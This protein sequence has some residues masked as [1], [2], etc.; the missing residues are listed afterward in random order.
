MPPVPRLR[1]TSAALVAAALVP[2]AACASAPA[3]P[4][5]AA[6]SATPA[7]AAVT[8]VTRYATWAD[9][10]IVE[11]SSLTR[12][13]DHLITVNDSGD[14]P[15][16]FVSTGTAGW[17]SGTITYADADPRDVEALATSADGTI[18]V[19]DIGDNLRVRDRIA[20][21]RLD[22]PATWEGEQRVSAQRY[23]LTYPDGAHDAETLLVD[24]ASGEIFIVTKDT[25]GGT[26]YAVPTLAADA[27]TTLV[28][29]AQVAPT[30]TDGVFSADGSM[31][32][33]RTYDEVTAYTPTNCAVIAT[34]QL[35]AEPK[36]E[37]LTLG[38]EEGTYLTSTEGMAT[39]ITQWRW[40][41]TGS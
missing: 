14:G 3:G 23:D 10:R 6:T 18:W 35:P 34:A 1:R 27:T 39:A 19:G 32:L 9:E 4:S 31:V 12:V 37:G 20:I 17:V 21:Y 33:L 38:V 29:V 13:G 7:A 24:P 30:V 2:L 40:D 5:T 15:I 16:L 36:G 22:R 25:S 28:K 8:E 41:P 26:V 11:S